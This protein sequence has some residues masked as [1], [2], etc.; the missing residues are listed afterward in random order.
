MKRIERS[1]KAIEENHKI[2]E[3]KKKFPRGLGSYEN[4]IRH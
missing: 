2:S 3:M 1:R 4:L